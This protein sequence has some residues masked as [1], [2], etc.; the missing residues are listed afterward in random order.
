MVPNAWRAPSYS[1]RHGR[2]RRDQISSPLQLLLTVQA[3]NNIKYA[4]DNSLAR[5]N[6]EADKLA[7]S[8][9]PSPGDLDP[10][11]LLSPLILPS[12]VLGIDTSWITP[13]STEGSTCPSPLSRTYGAPLSSSN[14]SSASPLWPSSTSTMACFLS[15]SCSLPLSTTIMGTCKGD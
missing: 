1:N 3:L 13:P 6:A 15:T 5:G 12:E 10:R 9:G 4:A 11:T 2:T 14:G 8:K 7:A